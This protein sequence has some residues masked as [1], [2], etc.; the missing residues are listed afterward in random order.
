MEL[1]SSARKRYI[2]EID[3]FSV[4]IVGLIVP[5]IIP[6]NAEKFS[7]T[8][9]GSPITDSVNTTDSISQSTFTVPKLLEA[10]IGTFFF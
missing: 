8:T 6:T 1:V 2:V 9:C 4:K 3:S 10:L 5:A 7:F